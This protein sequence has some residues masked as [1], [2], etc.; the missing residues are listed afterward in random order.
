LWPS[1]AKVSAAKWLRNPGEKFC[2]VDGKKGEKGFV[3]KATKFSHCPSGHIS[4]IHKRNAAAFV[5]LL[6]QLFRI[7]ETGVPQIW[8]FCRGAE[9]IGSLVA[10]PPSIP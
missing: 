1:A 6:A 7:R 5:S 8:F 10:L 9:S 2:R 3:F 4:K